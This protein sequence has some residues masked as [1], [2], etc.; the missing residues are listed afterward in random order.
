MAYAAVPTLDLRVFTPSE[1]LMGH[2]NGSLQASRG[3][4]NY[5]GDCNLSVNTGVNVSEHKNTN[6]WVTGLP[7][8]ITVNELL[9]AIT[10][11]GRIRSTV[12]NQPTQSIATAAASISFFHRRDAVKL[13]RKIEQGH[14]C[15]R[16]RFPLV[17]WNRNKVGESAVPPYT[18]RVLLIAGDPQIVNEEFLTSFFSKKFVYDIDCIVDHGIVDGFEG[19]IGRIEYRFGSWRSQ[20]SSARLALLLE[21]KGFLLVKYGPDPCAN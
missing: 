1:Q 8:G 21:L 7:A 5:R 2:S 17:Q 12:I 16:G 14:I 13:Y 6:L 18:T 20:A 10:D 3:N 9:G 15:L 19:P 11:T 4:G